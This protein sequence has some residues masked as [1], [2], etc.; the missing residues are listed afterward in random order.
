MTD[1]EGSFDWDRYETELTPSRKNTGARFDSDDG[2][3]AGIAVATLVDSAEAQREP[4]FTVTGL[5]NVERRPIVPAWVRSKQE[6]TDAAR[7]LAA[8]IGHSTAYHLTRVPKYLCKVACRSPRGLFRLVCGASRWVF[9]LEGSPV[10][11][12]AV[13]R[14]DAG[15]YLVLSRQR[16]ARVRLR[17]IVAGAGLAAVLVGGIVLGLAAAGW[18]QCLVLAV[19]IGALGVAGAPADKPLLDTAVVVPKAQKL[20]SDIVIRA[21][22]VLSISGINQALSKDSKA[23]SFPA[24]ITRDGPGWRADVD[25][26]YGVTAGEVIERRDKLASGLGRPLGCVWPESHHEVHP[27]RLML[28]VGDNDMAS[29][30]QPSWPLAR[31]EKVDLFQPFPF[32]T[33][34]RGR[35]VTADLIYTNVLIGSL[36]GAGKTF[37]LRVPLLAAAL[38]PRAQM[39]IF[40]LKGTGDLDPLA[41]VA[42]RYASGADDEQIEQ[43]LFALRDLRKE[44]SVRAARIK[45]LPKNLCPENKVTPELASK[46]SLGLHPLVVAIDECQ[47][48]FTHKEFGKEAGKLAEKIIKL[49]RAL[50]ITLLLATQRPDKDS[51]PTGVSANVGTR[52]CLRVIGHTE[53]DMVL[54]SGMHKKG[55]RATTFTKRDRGL[56]YLVGAGDDPQIVKTFYIDGPAAERICTRARAAREQAGTLTGHAAGQPLEA[57]ERTSRVDTLLDDILT[58]VPATEAKIW[59][60]LVV[61]RLA[62]YRPELYGHWAST[63]KPGEQLTA[64]LKR[65]GIAT[66]Q[67]WGTTPDGRGANRRG[68]TRH[69][70]QQT[71]TDRE[72][73]RGKNQPN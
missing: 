18:I 8:H 54:G 69:T 70:I 55:I 34:P 3:N 2:D 58:V 63:D 73:N 12:A 59:N 10:R 53:N 17:G 16:D 72:Q 21:L 43:A 32:G 39:W 33:D 38:D 20:T 41:H 64:A 22:S 1:S 24:P 31:S 37:A 66:G 26:P 44:C 46:K 27:A 47:E 23:I 30:R 57:N 28:W 60:E 68:I 11:A 6:L 51:L 9:D 19:L 71:V 4:R 15:E 5:R 40:E 45:Q 7:W 61:A 25:L 50:G 42:A 56:G 29:A 49:G 48:L 36:P 67:V 14:E 35:T 62:E 13:S 65:Y 52:F